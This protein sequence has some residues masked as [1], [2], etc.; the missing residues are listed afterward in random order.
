ME[1]MDPK[2]PSDS[3]LFSEQLKKETDMGS[4]NW[5]GKAEKLRFTIRL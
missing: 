5:K 2:N 4:V 3:D 1:G